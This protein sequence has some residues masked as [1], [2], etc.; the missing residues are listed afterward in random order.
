MDD[1]YSPVTAGTPGV[2]KEVSKTPYGETVY[3]VIWKNGSKLALIDGV[4]KWRKKI[5][6][7]LDDY[8]QITES[9][10]VLVRTKKD[11]LNKNF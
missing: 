1:E 3:Y 4:D 5:E 9:K 6:D 8:E 11:L 2:V 7:D 10:I